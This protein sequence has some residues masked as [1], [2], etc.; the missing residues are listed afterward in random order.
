MGGLR[1]WK[2]KC[3]ERLN[4]LLGNSGKLARDTHVSYVEKRLKVKNSSSTPRSLTRFRDLPSLERD[5]WA[6]PAQICQ[7]Y[8][9]FGLILNIPVGVRFLLK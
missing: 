3:I 8:L 9:I 1:L 2:L 6:D 4:I 5:D 7:Q